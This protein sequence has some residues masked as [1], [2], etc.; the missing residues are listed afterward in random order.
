M[1]YYLSGT[2]DEREIFKSLYGIS[3]DLSKTPGEKLSQAN[4]IKYL[5][6][7]KKKAE[8]KFSKLTVDDL[9]KPSIFKWH[10]ESVH[11]SLIYNLRHVMLHIG[12]LNVRLRNSGLEFKSWVSNKK[13]T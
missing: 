6:Q 2:R 1:D 12:A 11:S 8:E 4:C 3:P 13:L 10:G 5:E 9:T 7:V